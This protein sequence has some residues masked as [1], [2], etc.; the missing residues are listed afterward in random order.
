MSGEFSSPSPLGFLYL[1]IKIGNVAQEKLCQPFILGQSPRR[2]GDEDQLFHAKGDGWEK[3]AGRSQNH[4][5]V[6]AGK[7]PWRSPSLGAGD[8]G[9]AWVL[10]PAFP[11]SFGWKGFVIPIL[12]PSSSRGREAEAAASQMEFLP[13][14]DSPGLCLKPIQAGSGRA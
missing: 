1:P 7:D 13:G 6:W 14:R 10:L 12:S 11:R 5:I 8:S 2:V 9:T 4:G 3:R